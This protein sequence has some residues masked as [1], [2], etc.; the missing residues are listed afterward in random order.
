MLR[1]NAPPSVEVM[2]LATAMAK[3]SETRYQL[4]PVG[5]D[6]DDDDDDDA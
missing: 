3:L 2:D 1:R 4:G 5:G 6:D